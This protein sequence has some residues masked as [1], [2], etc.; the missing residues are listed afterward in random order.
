MFLRV[1]VIVFDQVLFLSKASLTYIALE[2]LYALMYGDK[3]SFEAKPRWELLSAAWHDTHQLSSVFFS[4]LI[5]YEIVK[6]I[7]CVW[8]SM[9]IVFKV[10]LFI[11]LSVHYMFTESRFMLLILICQSVF[12]LLGT[13]RSLYIRVEAIILTNL[14]FVWTLSTVKHLLGKVIDWFTL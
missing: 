2:L 3:V 14:F 9:I 11:W 7:R 13:L 8:I 5:L 10:L 4:L 12:I 6:L 1:N